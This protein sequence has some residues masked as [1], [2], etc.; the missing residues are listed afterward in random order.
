MPQL[1]LIV[2]KEVINMRLKT[3]RS[4]ERENLQSVLGRINEV[5]QNKQGVKELNGMPLFKAL[6]LCAG[7]SEI[8]LYGLTRRLCLEMVSEYLT[9]AGYIVSM[10]IDGTTN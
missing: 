9:N 6:D 5:I 1:H 2:H 4:P 10:D 8:V 3:A 7:Y